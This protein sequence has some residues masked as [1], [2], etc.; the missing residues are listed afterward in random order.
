MRPTRRQV[1]HGI[2]AGLIAGPFTRLLGG[3]GR[4]RAQGG[5]PRRLMIFHSPNGTIHRHWRPTG[6]ERDFVFPAGT[7]LEPLARRRDD[8]VIVDGLDFYTG[9]N[10]EGG[11]AAM[12]T[13]GG[14]AGTPTRG[15]SLDQFIAGRIGAEDRFTSLEF[16]V[17]TDLWG[18][19]VQTRMSYR[20]AGELVH[21]DADPRRAFG[22]MFADLLGGDAEIAR[23][24]LRRQS[25][26][27]LA[28]GE[29]DDLRRRVG[30]PEQIKLDAHLAAL[31]SVERSLFS[32]GLECAAP[33]EPDP[34]GKNEND[35]GPA[36]LD[37]QMD[38]AVAALSCGLTKVASVQ[39]SHTVSPVVFRWAGN[40]DGHHSLSHASDGEPGKVAEFIDAERWCAEQFGRLL[41]KLAAAPDPEGGSLLDS[42]LVLWAKEMG[43]SRAHV[44]EAVP[45][46]LAGG[47]A[48]AG[49]RYLRYDGQSHG[50]LLVSI[51]QAFGIDLDTFGDPSTGSGPLEGLV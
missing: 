28:R 5:G 30:R 11:M 47:G 19:G 14:G 13:N 23:R 42:T 46:V 25:V 27:D 41:D 26:I 12:L 22:R 21:P 50:H 32:D 6:G 4:A 40:T 33:G 44:C 35:N 43:D 8:L 36:L 49:G 7:V 51:A 9:T 34:L 18:G 10:H 39:F 31:R 37:A 1:L 3:G 24:R 2:G 15:A 17:L 38:L 16:G 29:L 48:F 45:F 20:T